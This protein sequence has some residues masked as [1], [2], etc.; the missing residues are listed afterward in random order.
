MTTDIQ[1]SARRTLDSVVAMVTA[2]QFREADARI[3][4][5]LGQSNVP[6]A[7][8]RAFEFQRVRMQRMRM[9]FSLDA[10]QVKAR[11]R[12]QI[13]DLT[14]AQ[15]ARW[16][17]HGLFEHMLIDGKRLYFRRAPSNLFR[18]SAEARKLRE[19]QSPYIG[20]GLSDAYDRMVASFDRKVIQQ[21][22]AT[23]KTSV[24]PRR[25]QVTQTLTVDAD[26]VPAGKTIRAWIP[27]PRA[28]P[29]QQE[30]IRFVSSQPSRHRIAPASTLQRTVYL[31]KTAQAGKPTVFSITYQVTLYAQY[32]A[33]D[34][35]KV[36]PAKITP[37]LKPFVA[38]RAP[39]VVFT[40][41]LHVFSD[42]V[43]GDA[44]NPYEIARRIYAAVDKIPWA[45][46]REYSTIA[47]ISDY[48]LH[49]GHGD[50]GEQ[51][52][53]L[54]TLMRMN[55]IPARWQSGWIYSDSDY[56]NIHDWAE[57]YLAPY[58][59]IPVDVTYGRFDTG[60]PA[61]KWFY[62]GGLDNYRIAFNDGFSQPFVPAKSSFRSDTVDS[63]RGEVEWD[64]GNL[65]YDQWS[66]HF[67]WRILPVDQ[68]RDMK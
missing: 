66:Y 40:Q 4:A 18:L 14:D 28:N 58:G 22:K 12:K 10:D 39:H 63:Q 9:D 44:T 6:A 20:S 19:E 52:L 32:H 21:A 45:G 50:C 15:F 54:I 23:G 53:L 3:G 24:L 1:T 25:L 48:T 68:E 43:V 35:D 30:D 59:W 38:E 16:D 49:A 46:A 8:R 67:D 27:Y 29:G 56:D 34:P 37:A 36:V 64:G 62:L 57:I 26:A 42:Q 51:T 61:L 65:Y 33:I 55:G 47:N 41:P 2:G 13:P 11:V 31:E 5:V 7:T 17:A 60:D